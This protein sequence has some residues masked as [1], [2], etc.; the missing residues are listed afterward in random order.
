MTPR[1]HGD[2][3][4][5]GLVFFVPKCPLRIASCKK[6]AF[7]SVKPRYR[8]WAIEF[9]NINLITLKKWSFVEQIH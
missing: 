5:F 1:L 7:L 3:S 9:E 4:I 8:T 2:F 6:I